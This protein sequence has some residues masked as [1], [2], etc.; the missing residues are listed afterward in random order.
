MTKTSTDNY[1]CLNTLLSKNIADIVINYC[2]TFYVQ[3][4]LKR[5]RETKHELDHLRHEI[6]KK[7]KLVDQYEKQLKEWCNHI[8]IHSERS[9][10]GHRGHTYY[11]CAD[12]GCSL[13]SGDFGKGYKIISRSHS[14]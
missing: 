12:C 8:N 9:W 7:T 11:S 2:P 3:H 4:C 6:Y 5:K 13:N 1:K 10:D 14:Y